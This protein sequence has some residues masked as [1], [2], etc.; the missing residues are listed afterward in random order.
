MSW[1]KGALVLKM[2]G[3]SIPR[4]PQHASVNKRRVAVHARRKRYGC[5]PAN[6]LIKRLCF[7]PTVE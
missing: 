7:R 3:M 5:F 1:T 4:K 6:R 2:C